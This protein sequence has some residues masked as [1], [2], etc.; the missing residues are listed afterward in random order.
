VSRAGVAH[1]RVY[2]ACVQVL[3]ALS[4][5]CLKDTAQCMAVVEELPIPLSHRFRHNRWLRAAP[6]LRGLLPKAL[7]KAFSEFVDRYTLGDHLGV[8][9]RELPSPMKRVLAPG[10]MVTSKA[11]TLELTRDWWSTQIKTA[12]PW[13]YWGKCP[14][15]IRPAPSALVVP[16]QFAP[17]SA[18]GALVGTSSPAA[19]DADVDSNPACSSLVCHELKQAVRPGHDAEEQRRLDVAAK[20]SQEQGMWSSVTFLKDVSTRMGDTAGVEHDDMDLYDS[21]T[22]PWYPR[23]T[24]T[25]RKAA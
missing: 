16:L 15:G 17:K 10:V 5:L 6:H 20:V 22:N 21:F 7:F 24:A 11:K 1:P 3:K 13:T 8:G 23:L 14:G 4:L 19:S 12:H 25:L 2:A 9:G 18:R